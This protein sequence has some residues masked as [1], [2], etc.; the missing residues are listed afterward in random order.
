MNKGYPSSQQKDNKKL[1]LNFCEI[2]LNK[3]II[4]IQKAPFSPHLFDTYKDNRN[5]YIH[6]DGNSLYTWELSCSE[7]Q[8]PEEFKPAPIKFEEKTPIFKKIIE[9]AIVSFFR[10]ANYHLNFAPKK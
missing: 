8:L 1:T 7:H 5:F 3:N 6:K 4:Q 9:M 10:G 2:I